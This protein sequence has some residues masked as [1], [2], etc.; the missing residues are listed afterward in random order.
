VLT[1]SFVG[2]DPIADIARAEVPE[3]S[4]RLPVS[5]WKFRRE[6]ADGVA[7]DLRR[8]AAVSQEHKDRVAREHAA[9]LDHA[10]RRQI[11]VGVESLNGKDADVL[12]GRVTAEVWQSWTLCEYRGFGLK[13]RI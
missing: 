2:S 9:E 6:W 8:T 11:G 7:S 12:C 5:G 3:C 13:P 10:V 4:E 1:V